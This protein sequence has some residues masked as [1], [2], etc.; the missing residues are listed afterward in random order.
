MEGIHARGPLLVVTAILTGKYHGLPGLGIVQ[1]H[2]L[3]GRDGV[4]WR[5]IAGRP[6]CAEP[7]ICRGPTRE[8]QMQASAK[9][10]GGHCKSSVSCQSELPQST[11]AL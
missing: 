11:S 4:E 2:R 1:R 7:A 3:T 9:H 5:E 6:S 8:W 10:A